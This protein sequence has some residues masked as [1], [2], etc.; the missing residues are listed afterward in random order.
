MP[1]LK[2]DFVRIVRVK[3]PY[4]QLAA[5]A[6]CGTTR[7]STL[8]RAA[9]MTQYLPWFRGLSF[10]LNLYRRIVPPGLLFRIDNFDG[11]LKL[12][13][14]VTETIG[15]NLWHTPR[16]YERA[17][18]KLFCAAIHP[19][20]VVLDVGAN[21]GVYTL[22]AAKRGATVFAI[23]ADS[24]NAA[25]LRRHVNVNGFSDRVTIKEMAAL[26]R[27]RLVTLW[28]NPGN[29][30]GHSIHEIHAHG[31]PV[32]VQGCTIDSLNLPPIELCKMDI[33]GAEH[34]AL[35]GMEETLRR[36]P[37]MQ[38]LIECSGALSNTVELLSLLRSKFRYIRV[39]GSAESSTLKLP[40]YC[41][42]WA[43]N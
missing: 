16:L 31:Q 36:S 5:E 34:H 42:L 30:G 39:V 15:V 28:R 35:L 26:E 33:E 23:E 24:D 13:V 25:A 9:R 1:L 3:A 8:L 41:N 18:R 12:E 29:S 20:S 37:K 27:S 4:P 32:S 2:S 40:A 21:I 14:N 19:G 43:S 10:L 17:E 38:L 22:L 6:A 7:P 11:D